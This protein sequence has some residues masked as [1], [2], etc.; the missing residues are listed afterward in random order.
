M[1]ASLMVSVAGIVVVVVAVDGVVYTNFLGSP[2]S[3]YKLLIFIDNV[4]LPFR[5]ASL[6]RWWSL[7][8][9]FRPV[10]IIRRYSYTIYCATA[11][12]MDDLTRPGQTTSFQPINFRRVLSNTFAAT[13]HPRTRLGNS[14]NG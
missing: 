10:H 1:P 11:E 13:V 5:T 6:E 9:T 14:F 12:L 3:L 7:V 8:V 2:L 4:L